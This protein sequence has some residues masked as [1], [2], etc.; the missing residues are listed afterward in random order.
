M[1]DCLQFRLL[2]TPEKKGRRKLFN[3]F[4]NSLKVCLIVSRAPVSIFTKVVL[5][6]YNT[7]VIIYIKLNNGEEQGEKKVF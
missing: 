7:S 5:K 6:I 1:D 4:S 2:N 3:K